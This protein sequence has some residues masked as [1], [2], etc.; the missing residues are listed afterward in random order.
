[1]ANCNSVTLNITNKSNNNNTFKQ[2]KMHYQLELQLLLHTIFIYFHLQ[3]LMAVL[4]LDRGPWGFCLEPHALSDLL[5]LVFLIQKC[6]V[7]Y[8]SNFQN[9][10]N[11]S[12]DQILFRVLIIM[13]I[14]FQIFAASILYTIIANCLI[15]ANVFL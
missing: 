2:L 9:V 6:N 7:F 14:V 13:S 15:T 1:M 11:K 12:I 10:C 8:R 4:V 3:L 5:T